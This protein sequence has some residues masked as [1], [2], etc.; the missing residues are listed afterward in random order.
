MTES[1]RDVRPASGL[2]L[3]QAELIARRLEQSWNTAQPIEP[4]SVS[5]DLRPEDAYSVQRAW[6][7]L[8]QAAGET[9]VGRKIG[10]TSEAMRRLAKVDE[11]DYGYLWGSREFS[12]PVAGRAEVPASLFIAPR[13]E[14]EIAFLLDRSLAGGSVTAQEVLVSTAALAPAVEIVDSR[15]R[16]WKIAFADTVADN[17][18]YGGFVVGPWSRTLRYRDLGTLATVLHRN[19]EISSTG[20]GV[21][22]LAG[23]AHAVAWLAN[24]LW[25]FGEP[26]QAGDTVLSGSL[27]AAIDA[28][29]GDVFTLRVTDQIPMTL[30]FV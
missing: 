15:I 19:G 25:Q 11:P 17:S 10:L 14:G 3:E 2:P 1:T 21:D 27:G 7:R 13:V 20:V 12:S 23:P 30:R 29:V 4:L 8:R 18:S 24:K 28:H 6:S 16:D 9:V 5:D 26:L 22:A